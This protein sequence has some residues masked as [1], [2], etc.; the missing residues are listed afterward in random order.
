MVPL[1]VTNGAVYQ[2]RTF[3]EHCL[4]TEEYDP[5]LDE[6]IPPPGFEFY[7][8]FQGIPP[9]MYLSTD[10]KS[11]DP[12][13][14]GWLL[15]VMNVLDFTVSWSPDSLPDGYV[16]DIDGV[17]MSTT[18][19]IDRL[20]AQT[21][22][23]WAKRRE[24]SSVDQDVA[25]LP[26]TL[27]LWQNAPNPFGRQTVIHYAVPTASHVRMFVVGVNGQL[28]RTLVDHWSEPGYYSLRWDGRDGMGREVS[29]G[30]YFYRLEGSGTQHV[31]KMVVLK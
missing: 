7:A 6:I 27:S 22:L 30:L 17:D 25:A 5:G 10:I 2:Y 24:L 31:R 9:Y 4:G 16:L 15:T 26:R 21:L 3:G 8:F 1:T 29:N 20:Y 19:H 28:I 23:I 13:S 12:D 14:V 11:S 18:D